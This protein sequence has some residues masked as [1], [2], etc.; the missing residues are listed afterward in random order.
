MN[1]QQL[2]SADNMPIL[3]RG[4]TPSGSSKSFD[5]CYIGS[6]GGSSIHVTLYPNDLVEALATWPE[7]KKHCYR[8]R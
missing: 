4:L 2:C 8:T 3:V 5:N 7:Y 6:T 1:V